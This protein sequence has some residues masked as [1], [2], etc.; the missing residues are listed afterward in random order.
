MLYDRLNSRQNNF[1]FIRFLAALLVVF[2]HSYQVTGNIKNEPLMVFSKGYIY[3]GTFSVIVFF[4]ISG[5]LITQSY[6]NSRSLRSFIMS[7]VLRIYPGLIGA[8]LVTV[9]LIGPIF[10]LGSLNAYFS[11]K[12]TYLYLLNSFC[13]AIQFH[14]TNLFTRNPI[15]VVNGCLWSLPF[16]LSCYWFLAFIGQ[17]KG[18]KIINSILILLLLIVMYYFIGWDVWKN[19]VLYTFFFL[20]G[21][22]YYIF[23]KRI[24]LNKYLSIILLLIL[25]VVFSLNI[26]RHIKDMA[27]AITLPYIIISFAYTKSFLNNFSKYGDFSYGIYI[28]GWLVQQI[29]VQ[30]FP[31]FE[32]MENFFLSSIIILIL[33]Y[34]SWHVIEKRFLRYK[35]FFNG[36]SVLNP[37]S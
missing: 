11:G 34:G 36:S 35:R 37:T 29:I 14:V 25:I 28:Y 6:S 18:L 20:S 30:L 19:V 21:S 26:N 16:E 4:M 31:S 8:V 27:V 33:A 23:R 15:H 17:L 32:H 5:F 22:T 9:F 24:I 7:R 3:L 2:S 1:D 10:T 12:E 13:L